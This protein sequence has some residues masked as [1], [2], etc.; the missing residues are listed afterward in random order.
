VYHFHH[1]QQSLTGIGSPGKVG[2]SVTD[3]GLLFSLAE[4]TG[5]IWLARR[6]R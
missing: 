2:L 1:T 4:T 6:R 5:N 3:G